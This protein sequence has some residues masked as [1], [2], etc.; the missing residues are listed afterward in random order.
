MGHY[1]R[2][3]NQSNYSDVAQSLGLS[4]GEFPIDRFESLGEFCARALREFSPNFLR[5]AANGTRRSPAG[6]KLPLESC[7]R[8]EFMRA[9]F[10]GLEV[11]GGVQCE[12]TGTTKR[13]L[14]F[15]IR[16]ARW[17]V[18]LLCEGNQV[19]IGEHMNR[20]TFGEHRAWVDNGSIMEWLVVDCRTSVPHDTCGYFSFF[21]ISRGDLKKKLINL[22]RRR[23]ASLARNL[24]RRLSE[25][26]T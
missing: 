16:D 11:R 13:C 20:F 8:W 17:A 26:A 6:D 3:I 18:Q 14:N 22:S 5:D 10:Q 12:W 21:L 25:S 9:I 2:N 23:F 7:Y 4:Q 15:Y 24:F 1:R 19:S